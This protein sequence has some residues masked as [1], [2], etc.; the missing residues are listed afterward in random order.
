MIAFSDH[1]LVSLAATFLLNYSEK[2]NL[3]DQEFFNP[4]NSFQFGKMFVNRFF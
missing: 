4:V 2:G 1:R 3:T